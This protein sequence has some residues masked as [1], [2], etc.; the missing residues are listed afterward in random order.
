MT[1]HRRTGLLLLL[2]PRWRGPP[3]ACLGGTFGG[4]VAETCGV[5]VVVVVVSSFTLFGWLVGSLGTPATGGWMLRESAGL[6][7]SVIVVVVGAVGVD[8]VCVGG[9]RGVRRVR[10]GC[11]CRARRRV[12]SRD[13]AGGVRFTWQSNGCNGGGGGVRNRALIP[14]NRGKKSGPKKKVVR[15]FCAHRSGGARG[16]HRSTFSRGVPVCGIRKKGDARKP[17]ER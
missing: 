2:P 11:H 10:R 1:R 14:Q 6:C 7:K 3:S 12:G 13:V 8:V 4:P 5:V 17:S 16:N 9:M 15:I